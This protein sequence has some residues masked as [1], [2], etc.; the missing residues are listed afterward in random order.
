MR[1]IDYRF[2]LQRIST[3]L[4]VS[5]LGLTLIAAVTGALLAYYYEPTAGGA[6]ESLKLLSTAVVNGA[7]VRS[8]HDTAGNLVIGLALIQLVVMFLGRQF[9]LSWL[10]AWTSGILF[11]LAAIGL[12]WTAMILD[13]DQIGYWRFKVELGNL[14]AI[15]LIGTQLTEILTGGIGINSITVQHLYALHSYLLA[16]AGVALAIV[17]LTALIS[18]DQRQRHFHGESN[19]MVEPGDAPISGGVTQG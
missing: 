6:H 2:A 3:V 18:Q 7:L 4:A 12:G 11:T 13:W 8:I 17:H 15:P 1:I 14:R 9:R 10:A 16:I 5:L 19:M